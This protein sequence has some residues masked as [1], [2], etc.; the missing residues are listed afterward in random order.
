MRLRCGVYG[1]IEGEYIDLIKYVV[2]IYNRILVL[3]ADQSQCQEA[4]GFPHTPNT[5]EGY[6][7]VSYQSIWAATRSEL[8]EWCGTI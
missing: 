2:L 4:D 6:I 8:T 7:R 3:R 1:R 5:T